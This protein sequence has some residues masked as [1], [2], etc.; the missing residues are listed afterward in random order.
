MATLGFPNLG[1][2]FISDLDPEDTECTICRDNLENHAQSCNG[3]A[4]RL[5]CGHFFGRECILTWLND[6]STCP[7]CRVEVDYLWQDM[8][9]WR[10]KQSLLISWREERAHLAGLI[11]EL[12]G[13]SMPHLVFFR[14][15][16]ELVLAHIPENGVPRHATAVATLVGVLENSFDDII[17]RDQDLHW[18]EYLRRV[19]GH[20]ERLKE[21]VERFSG[22]DYYRHSRPSSQRDSFQILARTMREEVKNCIERLRWEAM[23]DYGF[24]WLFGTDLEK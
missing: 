5:R 15:Q 21:V 16:V 2:I 1:R 3:T 7:T 18:D 24:E 4:A 12:R 8:E 13:E 10:F 11:D 20:L 19:V 22:P 6:H 14:R 9:I 17:D 23:P